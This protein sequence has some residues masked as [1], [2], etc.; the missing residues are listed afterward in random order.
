MEDFQNQKEMPKG[1]YS[2][3]NLREDL[4]VSKRVA[5]SRVPLENRKEAPKTG[6]FEQTSLENREKGQSPLKIALQREPSIEDFQN[7]QPLAKASLV[8]ENSNEDFQ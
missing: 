6:F 7:C 3:R 1:A 8:Q 5:V 2:E 4:K